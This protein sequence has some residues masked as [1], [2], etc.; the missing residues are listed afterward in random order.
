MRLIAECPKEETRECGSAV[1]EKCGR[2]KQSCGEQRVLPQAEGPEDG[3]ECK[4]TDE[5]RAVAVAEDTACHEQIQ[6]QARRLE[7]QERH[8]I[9]QM[10]EDGTQQQKRWRVIKEI[11]IYPGGRCALFG[12]VMRG[13]V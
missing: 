6:E 13:S 7:D 11:V 12:G 8:N 4:K 2:A 9:W 5:D 3:R 1:E 10:R